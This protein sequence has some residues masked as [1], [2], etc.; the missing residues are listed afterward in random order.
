MYS[1]YYFNS[2]N[3]F[4]TFLGN[5]QTKIG[6]IDACSYISAC[7]G[8]FEFF[9]EDIQKRLAFFMWNMDPK[10][11]A[12]G[13]GFGACPED[14]CFCNIKIAEEIFAGSE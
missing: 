13:R 4:V 6:E 10:Q 2:C 7:T 5:S 14:G 8:L 11:F 1:T 12:D 9:I 3:F